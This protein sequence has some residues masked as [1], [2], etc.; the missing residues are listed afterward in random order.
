MSKRS[1]LSATGIAAALLVGAASSQSA[2]A[3]SQPSSSENVQTFTLVSRTDQAAD[4]DVGKKGPSLGDYFVFSDNVLQNG[5]KVGTDGG[6]CTIVNLSTKLVRAQCLVTVSLPNGD[7]T[8]QG[9]AI[10][11][12]ANVPSKPNTLAITGG[13]RAYRTAQG[14]AT[15]TDLPN[16]DTRIV[17]RIVQQHD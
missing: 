14:D 1:V 15:V 11:P 13:T 16:G 9:I 10:F 2:T 4:I 6:T 12:I 8:V 3:T 17:V 5:K 7:L